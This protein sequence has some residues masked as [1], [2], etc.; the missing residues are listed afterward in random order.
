MVSHLFAMPAMVSFLLKHDSEGENPNKRD[1]SV[2]AKT[3]NR[4]LNV[5][6]LTALHVL[7]KSLVDTV[8]LK[9]NNSI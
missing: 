1:I 8:E 4:E 2:K 6:S 7:G 9:E 5:N 3:V